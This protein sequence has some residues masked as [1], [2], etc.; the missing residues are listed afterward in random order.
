MFREAGK[1]DVARMIVLNKL[2][3]D[4]IEFINAVKCVAD[5]F[6][7]ACVLFNAPIKPGPKFSGVVSVLNPPASAGRLPRRPGGPALATHRRRRRSR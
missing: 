3:G 1:R 7:K 6:G 5:T 2:D 4:N